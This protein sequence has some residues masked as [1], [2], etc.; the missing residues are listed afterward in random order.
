MKTYSIPILAILFAFAGCN[1]TLDTQQ[2]EQW[3]AEIMAVEAEFN[4]MA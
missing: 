4:T 3:K 1:K 2:L